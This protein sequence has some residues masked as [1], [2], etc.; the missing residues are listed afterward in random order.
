MRMAA[1]GVLANHYGYGGLGPL[2]RMVEILAAK[3]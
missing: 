2:S 3:R 1:Q